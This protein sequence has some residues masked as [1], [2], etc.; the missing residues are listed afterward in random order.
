MRKWMLLA[1]LGGAVWAAG[2]SLWINGRPA[3]N[4]LLVHQ[5]KSWV[6][7]DDLKSAGAQVTTNQDGLSIRFQAEGG[8][9]Q[10]SAV[11][12]KA[13]EWLFNGLWR[14]QSGLPTTI[15]KPYSGDPGTPGWGPEIEFRNG[16][17]KEVSLAQTGVQLP[18][19]ALANGTVLKA[20]E[21]DWQ[22]IAFRSMLP[23]A[24]VKHQLKFYF[25]HGTADSAIEKARRLVVPID[26][27]FGL[28]RDTGLRYSVPAPSFR[29]GFI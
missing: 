2:P 7:V 27:K 10:V 4:G 14:L 28:L 25:P 1:I 23:G 21:G 22:L 9:Q 11:E 5:G 26:P 18:T 3:P 24:S 15:R 19:L 29:I 17:K 12:G 8:A 20:D 13:D 16:A 6:C